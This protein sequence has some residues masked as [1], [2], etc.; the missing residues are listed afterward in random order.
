L[1]TT[2]FAKPFERLNSSLLLSAP[3]SCLRKATCDP[4]V[5]AQK[6]LKQPGQESVKRNLKACSESI[7]TV[8]LG[9]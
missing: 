2:G 8:L 9:Q 6:S 5:L 1:Q 4:V 7:S 3:E